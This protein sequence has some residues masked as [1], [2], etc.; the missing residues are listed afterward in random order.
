MAA[1]RSEID[2]RGT[3]RIKSADGKYSCDYAVPGDVHSSLI[4]AGVIPDP[5]IG[6]NEYDVRWVAE[7]D[8][9]ATR[10]FDWSRKGPSVLDLD[11]LDTVAEIKI[12]NK[13]VIRAENCF[14]RYQVDAS[15]ALKPGKN[16]I[17][18]RFFSNIEAGNKLQKAQP[19]FVPYISWNS[20]I[21]NGNML[22]KPSCHY[23]WD[24]NLAIMPFGAYGRMRLVPDFSSVTRV[25]QIFKENGSVEVEVETGEDAVV[26]FAGEARAAK[27]GIATFKIAKPKLWWP[28]SVGEQHLYDLQ[29]ARSGHTENLSI[30]L[31]QIDLINQKDKVGA[32]FGFRVNGKEIF[33][34][35]AN[36][37]CATQSRYARTYTQASS[38]CSQ[39]QYEH[40]PRLGWRLL[41]AGL[42]LRSL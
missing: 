41:R 7:L 17:E 38:S 6:R 4:T 10:E 15:K 2:L 26:T 29:I 36:C 19:Y 39:R 40:A 28:A 11:Y 31:R 34:R 12:N 24:W 25:T 33:C 30:G 37:R 21:P 27:N 22:R 3:W 13:S 20:P 16:K 42:V 32:R 1:G 9:I 8:W 18:I 35:G 23:G 14:Q 5:Y